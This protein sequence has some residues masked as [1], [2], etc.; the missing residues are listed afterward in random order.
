MNTPLIT[1]IVPVYKVEAYL[2]RCV[3]SVQNQT[4]QNLEIILVDDG[5]PD[6][7]GRMCDDYAA[8]D[9][10]IRVIHKENGGLSSARNTGLDVMTGEFV[11][12]LD[13]DDLIA[14]DMY[15]TLYG[16]IRAHKAQI[17]CCG[18]ERITDDGHL[19]Y[20]NPNLE[21]QLVLDR[22]Q[23]MGE[24]LANYR[25]TNSACDKLFHKSVFQSLRM[26]ENIIYEDFDVMYRCIYLSERVVYTGKPM[27][28]YYLSPASILRGNMSKKQYDVLTVGQKRLEFYAKNCAGHLPEAKARYIES[29][30]DLIYRSRGAE[31]CTQLRK[32]AIRE[33][34]QML[35]D[36]PKL[37]FPPNTALKV[38]C[39]QMGT[40]VFTLMQSLYYGLRRKKY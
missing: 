34:R 36:N 26:T 3:K 11:G 20:F 37:P 35:K 27:Y 14:P 24:L 39:F 15:E 2:D 22:E 19:D 12:F 10:R 16:L 4:Y 25:V 5:S 28:R 18:I 31:D 23:A 6:R 33:V 13:S 1:V 17:A 7:C 30:L 38:R 40:G 29:A 21:D 32:E 8:E 9:P